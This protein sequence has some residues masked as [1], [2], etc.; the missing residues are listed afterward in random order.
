MRSMHARSARRGLTLVEL[1][2]VVAILAILAGFL[3]PRLAFVRT[4]A[5]HAAAADQIEEVCN[6]M[7]IFHATQAAWPEK[8][9]T[10]LDTTGALS[11]NLDSGL[12]GVLTVRTMTATDV[13]SLQGLLGPNGTNG[14]LILCD[15]LPT[16]PA[17]ADPGD[18]GTEDRAIAAGS[19][20][21]AVAQINGGTAAG[22]AV[23]NA[24]YGEDKVD[25]ASG[26]PLDGTVLLC[27]GVGP[28]CTANTKTMVVPPKMFLKDASRY[29]RICVLIKIYPAG[30]TPTTFVGAQASLAGGLSPDGRSQ[31]KVLSDYR[32]TA[33]R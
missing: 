17:G 9:D 10:L 7:L 25:Q 1:A 28:N 33:A 8:F 30:T 27:L 16:L 2:V 19:T 11:A 4:L 12:A 26:L 20:T 15:A 3:A 13:K 31:S 21:D 24:V 18:M 32:T 23:Y 14:P 6:N 5:T 22:K 29:N